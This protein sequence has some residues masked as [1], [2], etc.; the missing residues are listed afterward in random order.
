VGANGFV[1]VVDG[2]SG[3]IQQLSPNGDR[4]TWWGR[5]PAGHTPHE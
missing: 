1:Y 5:R 2:N 3:G 4:L